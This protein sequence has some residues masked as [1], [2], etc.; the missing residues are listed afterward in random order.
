MKGILVLI[1]LLFS[2]TCIFAQNH[3][4]MIP[5]N[6]PDVTETQSNVPIVLRFLWERPATVTTGER[7]TIILRANNWSSQDPSSEFFK[8]QVPQGVILSSQP[9]TPEERA[10][11]IAIKLTLIPLTAGDIIIPAQELVQRNIIY[12]IPALHIR[13]LAR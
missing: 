3:P 5:R 4:L 7:I 8:P 1:L 6:N 2:F 13:V 9:L 11:G 12:V 10:S